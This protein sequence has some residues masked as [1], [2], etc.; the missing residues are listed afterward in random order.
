M[1][2]EPWCR[3]GRSTSDIHILCTCAHLYLQVAVKSPRSPTQIDSQMVV[4]IN[5]S[6]DR[7]IRIWAVL[8][9]PYVLRLYG[10]VR[11]FGPFCAL[12]T[13]WMPN[14]TLDSYLNHAD[15]T[16]MDRLSMLRQI[17][18]GLKYLHDNNVIHGDPDPYNVLVAADGSPRLADFVRWVRSRA[19][20]A[21]DDQ[22]IQCAT[23]SS[24][25]YSLGVLYG[26]QPYWWLKTP[27]HVVSARFKDLEPIDSSVKIEA[28]HLDCMRRCW[29]IEPKIRP[30]VEKTTAIINEMLPGAPDWLAFYSLREL[31]NEV[32]TA[33]EHRGTAAGGL[34]DIWKCSWCKNSEETKVAVKSVRIPH[35]GDRDEVIKMI[36]QEALAWAKSSHDNILPLYDTIPYFRPLPAFMSPW[37]AN[38]SLSDYLRRE[39]SRLSSTRKLDI[40]NQVV[41]GLKHLHGGGITHGSLTSDDVFLDGSG[42]VYIAYF[43]RLSK[44]FAQTQTSTS[45][46]A[47]AFELRYIA[48]ELLAPIAD[49]GASRPSRAGD[50]YSFGCLMIQVLSGKIPYE[51]IHDPNEVLPE[52]VKSTQPFRLT[53]ETNETHLTFGQQ[54][55]SVKSDARPSIEDVFC[56]FVVQNVGATDLTNFIIRDNKYPENCG[57]YA[58]IHM[59]RL[60][61][62]STTV[63]IQ[64]AVSSYQVTLGCVDVAVKALRPMGA[65]ETPRMIN[66]LLREIKISS[67]LNHDNIVP[68][69]GVTRQFGVFP[70]LV[71]PWLRNGTL[72]DYLEDKHEKL[73]S[74]DKFALLRDVARGLQYLHSQSIVHGDLSG[75]NVLIDD[76][77][78]ARLTDFGLSAFLSAR[79]S[80]ALLPTA[81]GGT[82]RWM[83]PENLMP[84]ES[85]MLSVFFKASD[86]YSFGGIML[87]V[88]EGKVPYHYIPNGGVMRQIL[89][90]ITPRRP[91]TP[92]IIDGDW[93]F[94]QRCWSVDAASRPS[95]TEV[96]T[97]MEE[98][99]TIV[100]CAKSRME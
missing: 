70:A 46:S 65:A 44:I 13:P 96:V 8:E 90:G 45:G 24:D 43:G 15:L 55:L 38:G 9:H 54:C 49:A 28:H 77:R 21:P 27:I 12:V 3:V 100:V 99:A 23:E 19:L 2:M 20:N 95:S 97:F 10:T 72:T 83:A 16:E 63:L 79:A 51:W 60:A 26:K 87:Q 48:P 69:W 89:Q 93:D 58:D 52:R 7:E 36:T 67:V 33:Y 82:P 5:K 91:D 76:D 61:L 88:L 59:C 66:R 81:V 73:S 84:D 35:T 14:G 68:L 30:S 41:A 4:R 50:I 94:I 74:G 47:N 22:P 92:V 42:R 25:I 53:Q 75:F 34:G 32:I 37:M 57:G 71:S 98:R 29:S 39:F 56:F 80:Q 31:P 17:A 40:L 1:Y 64:Q 78:K 62:D 6:L 11:D 85:D 86:V 18:E